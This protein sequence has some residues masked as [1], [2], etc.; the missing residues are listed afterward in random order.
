MAKERGGK[1]EGGEL[2]AGKNIEGDM[3]RLWLLIEK[4]RFRRSLFLLDKSNKLRYFA[5]LDDNMH[6]QSTPVPVD[7]EGA[8]F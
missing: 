3:A 5:L 8:K 1:R 6:N 4:V 7:F 2:G